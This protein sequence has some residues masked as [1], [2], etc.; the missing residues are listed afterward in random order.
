MIV[1]SHRIQAIL[2]QSVVDLGL[3]VA[4]SDARGG[5]SLVQNEKTFRDAAAMLSL[6]CET[7]EEEGRAT[8]IFRKR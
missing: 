1:Y 8:M 2:K 7:I 6:E 3:T 4:L 5:V